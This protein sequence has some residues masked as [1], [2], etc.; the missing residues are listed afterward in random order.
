M[1]TT[2]LVILSLFWPLLAFADS[3]TP[4]L[5]GAI[6]I[7]R[8]AF[9]NLVPSGAAG[10]PMLVVSTFGLLGGADGVWLIRDVGEGIG[11]PEAV[12]PERLTHEITWPNETLHV[13]REMFGSEGLIVSSGFLVPGRATGAVHWLPLVPGRAARPVK[14]TQDRPGWFY[15]RAEWK[16]VDAD[17]ALDLVCARARKPMIGAPGGELVWLK[18]PGSARGLDPQSTPWPMALL[19]SGPDVHFRIGDVDGNGT[20]DVLAAEFFTRRLTLLQSGAGSWN[21]ADWKRVTIDE[22]I[23]A[24]FDVEHVDLDGDGR[25]D[26]LATNHESGPSAGVYAYEMPAQPRAATWN[27]HVLL[28]RIPVLQPGIAAASPGQAR[29]FHPSTKFKGRRPWI[30]VSGDASRSVHLLVPRSEVPGDWRYD[31]HVILSRPSTIGQ[32]AVGDVDGDGYAE[33]FVPAYDEDKIHVLTF[34]PR[35]PDAPRP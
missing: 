7:R 32:C 27:R 16:D 22:N 30:L 2:T 20:D 25:K 33:L 9:L 14:L 8:P 12:T 21:D 11:S 28:D 23:G 5:L 6:P 10:H 26:V 17:G 24:A 18:S 13:P 4:R 19:A 29:T 1:R 15:H 31:H 34:G 3:V 35:R